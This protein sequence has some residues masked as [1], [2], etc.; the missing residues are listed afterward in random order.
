MECKFNFWTLSNNSNKLMETLVGN[1]VV[2]SLVQIIVSMYRVIKIFFNRERQ[3]I[4]IFET[5]QYLLQN[6]LGDIS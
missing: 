2:V 1:F 4:N 5:I 3:K 6:N